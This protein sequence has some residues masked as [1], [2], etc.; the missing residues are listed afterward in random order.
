MGVWST[1]GGLAGGVG[2]FF[3]GGPAGAAAGYGI[4]SSLGGGADSA[5]ASKTGSRQQSRRAQEA[6][7]LRR[8]LFGYLG[9]RAEPWMQLGQQAQM[10]L[11]AL[12]GQ[13][14]SSPSVLRGVRGP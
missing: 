4:G 10:P 5:K 6:L 1:L 11:W 12:A 13:R 2:G 3:L 14:S 9:Q 7:A 8:Q